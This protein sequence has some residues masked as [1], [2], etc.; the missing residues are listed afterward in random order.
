M[1]R[2]R[3]FEAIRDRLET[4]AEQRMKILVEVDQSR[5]PERNVA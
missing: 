3:V 1:L 5:L 4:E 2:E